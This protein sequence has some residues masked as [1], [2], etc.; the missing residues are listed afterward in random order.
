MRLKG[1]SGDVFQAFVTHT[2][3]D[4]GGETLTRSVVVRDLMPERRSERALKVAERR[5]HWLFDDA[6]VGITARR[7][8]PHGQ[9]VQSGLR[10]DG[11]RAG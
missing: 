3:F 6:P 2:V 10:G 4:E 11:R 7:S 9:P 8:G 1:R 5:F